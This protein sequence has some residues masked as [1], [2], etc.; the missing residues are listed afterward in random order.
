MLGH[1]EGLVRFFKECGKTL[2]LL[3]A[4]TGNA[5][6]HSDLKGTGGMSESQR[7][8]RSAQPLCHYAGILESG[9]KQQDRKLLS[10]ITGNEIIVAT[11]LEQGLAHLFEHLVAIRVAVPIVHLFEVVN[12]AK[13]QGQRV[14]IAVSAEPLFLR[15]LLEVPAV[16]QAGQLVFPRHILQQCL[17]LLERLAIADNALAHPYPRFELRHAKG[18][19]QVVCCA[20]LQPLDLV[21]K[22]VSGGRY[23]NVEVRPLLLCLDDAAELKAVHLWHH[24]IEEHDVQRVFL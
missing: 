2:W 16:V 22:R 12:V 15:A 14:V 6:T 17:L 5:K 8:D 3:A 21:L 20:Q 1:V 18:F 23:D 11:V 13:H 7:L 10:A 9:L 4:H 24:D 19:G